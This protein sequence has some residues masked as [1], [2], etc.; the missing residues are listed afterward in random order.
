M[1]KEKRRFRKLV[2]KLFD[3]LKENLKRDRSII[4][5]V[6]KGKEAYSLKDLHCYMDESVRKKCALSVLLVGMTVKLGFREKKAIQRL[7]EW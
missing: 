4:Q 5:D 7:S 6:I 2:R 1:E 3:G